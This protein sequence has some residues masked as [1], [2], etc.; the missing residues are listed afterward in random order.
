M[1]TTTY[2]DLEDLVGTQLGISEWVA[3][4]QGMINRFA[5]ATGDHQWIHVDVM[6]AERELGG[7]IA[8]GFLVLS[9]NARLGDPMLV[10]SDSPHRLNYGLNKVRFTS[11]VPSG[12]RVRLV[13]ILRMVEPKGRG[14]L[15]TLDCVMELEGSERP[16]FVA[17]Q[18]VQVRPGAAVA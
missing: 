15:L 16:A 17:E 10:V 2:T 6:R 9:L 7:T 13:Q 3:I 8:H 4:D 14:K 5:D 18:L 12:S 1:V 11:P